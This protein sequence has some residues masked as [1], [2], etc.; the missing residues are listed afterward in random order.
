MTV[1]VLT[2][3]GDLAADL[4][5]LE[6]RR[7]DV[8]YRRLNIDRFPADLAIG[9]DPGRSC[10]V[11]GAGAERFRSDEIS[12]TWCRRP[13]RFPR[14][15][16]YVNRES[17]AFLDG[18][19]GAMTWV[20]V[21]D[22]AAVTTAGNK[23]WQLR[24]A[25]AVGLEVPVTLVTNQVEH[26]RDRF[27][28]G[29]VIAKTIGGAGIDRNGIRQH[30]YSQLLSPA[31]LDPAAVKAAPCIFQE[32]VKPGVDVRV[33]VADDHVFATDID[34][35]AEFV[36]WRAAP[37]EAVGYRPVDV[38]AE[39]AERCVQL[40]RT[41]GLVYGAFDF[42]RQPGGRYVFLEVNPSGQWGWIERATGQPIT[43]AIAD[44]LV[45]HQGGT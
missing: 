38:P 33:T 20:W 42:V 14:H 39:V 35:P 29:S 16:L 9:Y 12:V 32:P 8:T 21:N 40:C 3:T 22:P 18:V 17:E 23:L 44:I 43:K 5:V 41:A 15:D 4:I 31:E 7:R 19:W 6:L 37:P 34:A 25:P 28:P 24:T 30:L 10:A 1:L 13:P 27:R 2:E 36:D 45:S 26:V 11:F